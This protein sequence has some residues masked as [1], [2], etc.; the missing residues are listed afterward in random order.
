MRKAVG[1]LVTVSVMAAAFVVAAQSA[2]LPTINDSM[3]KVM[4]VNA[5]TI[6]D[7]SSKAF[8]K[9]GDGLLASKVTAK[10]WAQLEQAGKAI[11][12]RARLLAPSP[13]NL[14]VKG[15]DEHI[16]GEEF[17]R[18]GR[19]G[20]YDAANATQIKALI[21]A[22]PKLFTKKAMILADAMD[23]L[24]KAS[25]RRDVKGLYKVSSNLDELCDGCHEPFWGTDEPPTVTPQ[26]ARKLFAPKR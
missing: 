20:E 5:Q 18:G 9:R 16:L 24:V 12:A 26:L 7:I 15:R 2:S 11:G 1:A 4:S 13:T 19:K 14:V 8:N 25:A 22:N 3:T 10:D 17:S 23:S 6:W 21:N